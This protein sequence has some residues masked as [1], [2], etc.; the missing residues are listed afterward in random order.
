MRI[1]PIEIL[2]LEVTVLLPRQNRLPAKRRNWLQ[3]PQSPDLRSRES[4]FIRCAL[5]RPSRIFNESL[6]GL[7]IAAVRACGNSVC[8]MAMWKG[9]KQAVIRCTKLKH[10]FISHLFSQW[11][12]CLLGQSQ[13]LEGKLF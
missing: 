7:V 9:M 6:N 10:L 1:E 3:L 13:F 11:C 5:G 8:A 4:R 2:Q 12:S